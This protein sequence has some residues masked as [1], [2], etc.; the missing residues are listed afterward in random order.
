MEQIISR[1][2]QLELVLFYQQVLNKAITTRLSFAQRESNN[3]L[4][5]EDELPNLWE[6]VQNSYLQEAWNVVLAFQDTLGSFLDQRGYWTQ[7]LI[8][9]GWAHEAAQALTDEIRM[10]RCMH[11]RADI[12]HQQGQY[13]EAER[14]Y[15]AC[16]SGFRRQGEHAMAM[17]SRHMRSLAVRGQGR[18]IEAERL[19]ES[20]LREAKGLGQN[21]WLAHPFYVLAL[22]ARDRGNYHEATQWIRES[23]EHLAVREEVAMLA[24]CH[25]FL[26]DVA[27]LQGDVTGARAELE[28]SLQLSRQIGN[29]RRMA[30]TIRQLGDLDRAQRNYEQARQCYEEALEIA[31]QLGDQPEIGRLFI[32]QGELMLNLKQPHDAVLFLTGALTTYKAI[33]HARG[34]AK[35]ALLLLGLH[36]RQGQIAQA[37]RVAE[38]A[39]RTA[40]SAGILHPANLYRLLRS[41]LFFTR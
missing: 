27:F 22:L 11:D 1:D 29:L 8:L 35:A 36:L 2:S 28:I 41:N 32:A 9:N 16:E 39:W 33:G 19:C 30:T 20:V 25:H 23:L 24:Q 15:Q 40:N 3:Y 31:S 26:G 18:Y 12:L 4:A 38:L 7:S 10:V 14:L 13:H 6:V 17:K 5:L 37:L 34:A 21:Q